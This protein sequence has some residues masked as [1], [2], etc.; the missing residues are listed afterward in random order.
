MITLQKSWFSYLIHI[1]FPIIWSLNNIFCR[2][3]AQAKKNWNEKEKYVQKE[4]SMK[5]IWPS[6]NTKRS[7]QKLENSNLHSDATLGTT[8]W[9]RLHREFIPIMWFR[10]TK[11][12]TRH[13]LR[14]MYQKSMAT[15]DIV[16]SDTT[17]WRW[18]MKTY[19]RLVAKTSLLKKG[20]INATL[21]A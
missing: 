12:V 11:L 5:D 18:V 2:D 15:C 13:C 8:M 9:H 17:L 20:H 4:A 1:V 3:L 21:I 16:T 14:I 19:Q 6:H 10:D 7:F